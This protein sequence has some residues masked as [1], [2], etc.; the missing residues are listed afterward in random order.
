MNIIL[1]FLVIGIKMDK[2]KVFL[3]TTALE[4]FW[5]ENFDSNVF[6]GE[7]CTL[8]KKD[9]TYNTLDYIWDNAIKSDNAAI[10]CWEVYDEVIVIL[11]DI[12][13]K[14]HNVNK[15]KRY[16]EIIIG[17]WLFT[18]IETVYDK[19]LTINSFIKKY[20]N[21][22]TVFLSDKCFITPM[23]YQDFTNKS[24]EEYYNLQ[25]YT[26]ILKFKEYS[27]KEKDYRT[28]QNQVFSQK[29]DFNKRNILLNLL[30][31]FSIKPMVTITSPYFAH[32]FKSNIKL[33][34]ESK[35]KVFFDD[36]NEDYSIKIN[37]DSEKREIFSNIYK[38]NNEFIHLLFNLCKTSFPLLFLEGYADMKNI[39]L[40]RK[41]KKT[42][43]FFTANALHY[44]YVY[45]FW[46][47]EN[48]NSVKLTA[49]QHGG[50]FGLRLNS[51]EKYEQKI[52]DIL[53]TWGWKN[54]AKTFPLTH[55]KINQKIKHKDNGYILYVMTG[56]TR[57]VRMI[58][59]GYTSS[60]Y[61]TI[62]IPQAISF[63][64][65][66]KDIKRYFRRGYMHDLGF[67]ID[68][69]IKS[70]FPNLINDNHSKNF[71]ARL[72]KARLYVVDHFDTTIVEVLAMNFP[73]VVFIN[74]DLYVFVK[75]ELIQVLVD[76][77]ILFYDEVEAAKHIDNIYYNIEDWWTTDKVQNARINFC[78]NYAN[79]SDNWAR[80]WMDAFFK[81]RKD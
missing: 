27:F 6:L 23:E 11:T 22:E 4:E 48:I 81:I 10:Y 79:T 71:H 62:Y 75:P 25:L 47:A 64:S 42:D 8:N 57:Y 36:F 45:K 65:S 21:F 41:V 13:N 39:S 9:I 37:K 80:D 68:H 43:L 73:A 40:S 19:Y 31:I 66:V 56:Y 29:K 72:E 7:W 60:L 77:N 26:Q 44:N 63:L 55:E 51:V 53:F 16:W 18:F 15:D 14:I 74:K 28:E 1:L 30:N 34:Y 50:G 20:P 54:N 58:M 49:M 70:K 12:L 67:H 52:S 38:G 32:T 2:D 5:D 76:A 59:Y 35:G 24:N 78:K 46:I 3:A 61:K 17:N 33:M 69:I